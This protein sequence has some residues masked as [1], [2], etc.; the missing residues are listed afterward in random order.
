MLT[1]FKGQGNNEVFA[2]KHITIGTG[3][4]GA[5]NYVN[6]ARLCAN[7]KLSKTT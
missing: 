1:Q 3:P 2:K 5:F 7:N 4:P 6:L